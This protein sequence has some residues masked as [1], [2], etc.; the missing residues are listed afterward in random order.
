VILP[1][2]PLGIGPLDFD[3]QAGLDAAFGT[4]YDDGVRGPQAVPEEFLQ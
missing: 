1:K 3:K 2:E 4:G